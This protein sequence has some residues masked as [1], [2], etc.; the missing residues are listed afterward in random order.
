MKPRHLDN[1]LYPASFQAGATV[2]TTVHNRESCS[3]RMEDGDVYSFPIHVSEMLLFF[4]TS[5]L[6]LSFFYS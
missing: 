3:Y 2:I 1:R 4:P 6:F 5:L